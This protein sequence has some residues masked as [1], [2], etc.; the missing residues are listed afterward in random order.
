MDATT[1]KCVFHSLFVA[2]GR[3]MVAALKIIMLQSPSVLSI[4]MTVII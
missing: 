2:S 1:W 4:I 3:S